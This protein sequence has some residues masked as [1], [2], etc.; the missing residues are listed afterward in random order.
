MKIRVTKKEAKHLRSVLE[1]VY[2]DRNNGIDKIK[3]THRI[4][5]FIDSSEVRSIG[6]VKAILDRKMGV[7][8]EDS[9]SSKS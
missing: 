3:G 6:S 1:A 9:N 5:V 8:T 7:I 2:S 4:V